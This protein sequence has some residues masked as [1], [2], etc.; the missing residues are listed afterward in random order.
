[1]QEAGPSLGC[2]T[3]ARSRLRV[4]LPL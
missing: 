3:L 4:F 2:T 1:V